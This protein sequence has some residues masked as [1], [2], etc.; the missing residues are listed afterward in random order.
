MSDEKKPLNHAA[1]VAPAP[2]TTPPA[3]SA[4]PVPPAGAPAPGA[5]KPPP[6]PVIVLPKA[7]DGQ[8]CLRVNGKDHFIDPK[9]YRVLIA[10]LHD[11][12]YSVPHFCYHPGLE[13]DGN[14]RMCYINQIDVMSGKPIMTPNL[15]YQPLQMYPKPII[16]C[17]EPLN[18]KGMVIETET[19]D[20]IKARSWV[21]EFL[22]INH[23]LDC[24]VCDKAGEC[25]LQD[26]S[27]AH[28]NADS[29]FQET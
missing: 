25:M 18:P 12:G 9:K 28:G 5:P 8:M 13:P 24:P 19:P 14:C 3:P 21:M 27:Y 4:P 16:S 26:N 2:A 23:P 22:L 29:R 20:V 17:R 11:L 15:A 6:A 10:A 7:P 1:V